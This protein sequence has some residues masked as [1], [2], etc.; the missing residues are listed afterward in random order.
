MSRVLAGVLVLLCLVAISARLWGE[1]TL[2]RALARNTRVHCGH[3]FVLC[4]QGTLPFGDS[5]GKL[6]E[7][8]RVEGLYV[9]PD[10]GGFCETV[11]ERQEVVDAGRLYVSVRIHGGVVAFAQVSGLPAKR[12]L[13]VLGGSGFS[14]WYV[15][16]PFGWLTVRES[17]WRG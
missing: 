13:K 17:A 15:F 1:E 12:G 16:T 9:R 14:G 11:H 3:R 7:A 8:L 10:G 2:Y 4:N 6:L 5:R